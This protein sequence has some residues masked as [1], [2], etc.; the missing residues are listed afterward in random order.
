MK[1]VLC[2]NILVIVSGDVTVQFSLLGLGLKALLQL[3][4]LQKI[5][6]TRLYPMVYYFKLMRLQN[7]MST[8]EYSIRNPMV[9]LFK[10]V[11]L[12]IK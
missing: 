3:S 9:Y 2:V 11:K 10:L 8:R 5:T 12:Q 1:K 6:P 7:I 4:M